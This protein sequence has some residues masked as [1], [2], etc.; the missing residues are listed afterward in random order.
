MKRGYVNTGK[1][2][3]ICIFAL[4]SLR[5]NIDTFRV[6]PI[7]TYIHVYI[8]FL[9]IILYKYYNNSF[10]NKISVVHLYKKYYLV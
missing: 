4:Q 8:S 9:F 10:S 6:F 3:F 1:T 2:Y 5:S 7:W